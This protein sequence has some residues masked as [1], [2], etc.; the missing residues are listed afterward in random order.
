MI[1]NVAYTYGAPCLID[2]LIFKPI[3]TAERVLTTE[4]I[5]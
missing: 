2:N 5:K 4:D 3:S 1:S